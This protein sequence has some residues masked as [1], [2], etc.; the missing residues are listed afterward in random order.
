MISPAATKTRRRLINVWDQF[1]SALVRVDGS[2]EG[3]Y[4]NGYAAVQVLRTDDDVVEFDV[5]PVVL[6]VPEYPNR[7]AQ[8]NLYLV[9]RGQLSLKK[10]V[11]EWTDTELE[12]D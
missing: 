1:F 9:V 3:A 7:A 11:A 4:A 2:F 6:N 5:K 12:R 8:R 10:A